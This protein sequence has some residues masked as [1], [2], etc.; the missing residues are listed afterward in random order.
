MAARHNRRDRARRKGFRHD[1]SLDLVAPP[2][3]GSALWLRSVDDMLDH[4]DQP[5]CARCLACCRSARWREGGVRRPLTEGAVTNVAAFGAF[6]DI[7]VHQDGLVHVSALA[8]T[9]VKDPHE[10]VKPGQIV[11]VKVMDLDVK[12]QRISLTMRLDDAAGTSSREGSASRNAQAGAG[13][14]LRERR[15]AA[16]V[17][18]QGT[19]SS[20]GGAIAMAL[21]RAKLKK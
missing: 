8:N 15:P 17:R 20:S 13:R 1:P 6:V 21:A 16:P 7:G 9:F 2:P 10:V 3:A 5:L 11:K 4:I 18:A 12:R 19:A 14:E